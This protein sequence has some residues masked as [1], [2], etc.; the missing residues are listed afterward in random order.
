MGRQA[1]LTVA[2]TTATTTV[3]PRAV[4]CRGF[5]ANVNNVNTDGDVR[6]DWSKEEIQAIYDLPLMDLVFRA[7]AVHRT[8]FNSREVQ[9][10]TL[11]SIK[12][13]GCV[14]DCKYC[15]QSSRYSTHVKP[16]PTLK[17]MEV[18]ESAR[19]AKA[20][21]STRFC[22]G[23][24]W[25]D[26]GE[27]KDR[28][29]FKS[30][31]E[32]VRQVKGMGLEVCCTLGML[33]YD[34]AVQ[35]KEAGL[36]AYNHNLDTSR[37]FYPE[38]ISTR[39]YDDRL[40][41]I[42][43]VR[44]AG[45]S[46]CSGGILGLGEQH[47]DRVGLLHQLATMEQHPESVPINALVAVEGTPLGQAAAATAT[48]GGASVD[49]MLPKAK[50]PT[51]LEMTRMIATSRIVLPRTMVRLSAGRMGFT[52][53]EQTLM[54]LA[55]AN[56]I[57]YGDQ[58]LTTPNPEVDK[59]KELFAALGLQGKPP[60]SAPLPPNFAQD[61]NGVRVDKVVQRRRQATAVV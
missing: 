58:L 4:S 37:E 6:M 61:G 11:L 1:S 15:S 54:F 9:Q 41:T 32:M 26:V 46:V 33:T 25:R 3:T 60:H 23:A 43:N 17:V 30:V 57:F 40:R 28:A 59:D 14:E 16:T 36:T 5:S 13:G 35:L 34:Q 8:H 29:A 50:P 27:N 55:G 53:A 39:S 49:A 51:A 42:D 7:A 44:K 19:R 38:V 10:C 47:V 20:A 18:V 45:L 24:A 22:M 56:S 21:G 2:T 52:Q 12:T 48:A 31:L